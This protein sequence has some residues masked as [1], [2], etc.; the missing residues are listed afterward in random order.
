MGCNF[1]KT[2]HSSAVSLTFFFFHSTGRI[3]QEI[4]LKLRE[5][6]CVQKNPQLNDSFYSQQQTLYPL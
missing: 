3:L 1:I 5:P 4:K 6:N 2:T